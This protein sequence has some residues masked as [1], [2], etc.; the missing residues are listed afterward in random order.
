M[1]LALGGLT[2]ALHSALP[3]DQGKAGIS[4][5]NVIKTQA[6]NL[7]H[8]VGIGKSA[9]K[10]NSVGGKSSTAGGGSPTTSNTISGGSA[11]TGYGGTGQSL[12]T[13]LNQ[14]AS[15]QAQAI[16]SGQSQFATTL[17][18]YQTG[19]GTLLNTAQQGQSNVNRELQTAEQ[20]KQQSI[21]SLLNQLKQN[22]QSDS[23]KL[24]SANALG[25]S[26]ADALARGEVNYGNQQRGVIGTQEQAALD[27]AASDQA[28][29][30]SQVQTGLASLHQQRDDAVTQI[31]NQVADALNQLDYYANGLGLSGK[32]QVDALKNQVVND[33]LG[34]L[35]NVDNWLTTQLASNTPVTKDQAAAKA[36]ADIQAGNTNAGNPFTYTDPT[37][38][39][40][41][42]PA[43]STTQATDANGNDVDGA[44]TA[45]LSTL[46]KKNDQTQ[47]VTA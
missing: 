18:T 45:L 41:T 36:Y 11:S 7:A 44:P 22:S 40:T 34:K 39:A 29:L 42:T 19:A 16:G 1:G 2:Q 35:Q 31:G 10:S 14:I 43:T 20:N 25:S 3:F 4:P 46:L 38:A 26:A 28:N 9:P 12:A 32:V 17:G 37:N 8:D 15:K 27:Q 21:T 23:V 30:N 5:I 24:S 6:S 47:P 13:I 33:G